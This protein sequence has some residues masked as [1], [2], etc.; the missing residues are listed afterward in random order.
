MQ[1]ILV[2]Q[3]AKWNV[4]DRILSGA[5]TYDFQ[6]LSFWS[7]DLK[8]LQLSCGEVAGIRVRSDHTFN[9]I[10]PLIAQ[11]F[12]QGQKDPLNHL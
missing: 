2:K 1:K 11:W 6:L 3:K 10:F 9:P 4:I 7:K 8:L 12:L 5:F